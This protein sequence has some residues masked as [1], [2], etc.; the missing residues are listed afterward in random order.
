MITWRTLKDAI[1]R[2]PIHKDAPI[3]LDNGNYAIHSIYYHPEKK[4][5]LLA[6]L[7]DNLDVPEGYIPLWTMGY[8]RKNGR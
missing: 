6:T 2:N 5:I 7:P 8:V 3:F 4:H 1:D